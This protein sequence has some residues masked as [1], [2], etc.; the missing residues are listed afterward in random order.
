MLHFYCR[1][2][3]PLFELSWPLNDPVLKDGKSYLSPELV[4]CNKN[5]KA[6]LF[7]SGWCLAESRPI[8]SWQLH[9]APGKSCFVTLSP[10]PEKILPSEF[11]VQMAVSA[12]STGGQV[13]LTEPRSQ[14]CHL[15]WGRCCRKSPECINLLLCQLKAP[16]N[17]HVQKCT[18][19]CIKA[20]I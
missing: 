2:V 9:F 16:K 15:L 1:T 13:F 5:R 8:C 7:I 6:R 19:H 4:I 3:L 14:E 10:S 18:R 11:R 20:N 17:Y 12:A